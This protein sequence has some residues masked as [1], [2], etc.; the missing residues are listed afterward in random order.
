MQLAVRSMWA[1]AA[2]AVVAAA[3]VAVLEDSIRR[4]ISR[5]LASGGTYSDSAG[6]YSFSFWDSGSST[7]TATVYALVA[8]AALVGAVILVAL[9]LWMATANRNGHSWARVVATVFGSL[10]A[11]GLF[12]LLT[13]SDPTAADW[14]AVVCNLA[15]IAVGVTALILMY[16]PESRA[17]YRGMD[18][19]RQFGSHSAQ[20]G[21][22]R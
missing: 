8:L 1:G 18:Q 21:P 13:L 22:T 9:W 3:R 7:T 20:Y 11:L 10:N 15:S 2:I 17:Y 16:Q 5:Q 6:G 19:Y 12:G 4:D 14:W